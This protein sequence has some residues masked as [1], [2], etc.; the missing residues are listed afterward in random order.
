MSAASPDKNAIARLATDWALEIE[1]RVRTV[2]GDPNGNYLQQFTVRARDAVLIDELATLLYVVID[3]S[4]QKRVAGP[5]GQ[6]EL[7][8]GP[9]SDLGRCLKWLIHDLQVA[10]APY[11]AQ[12]EAIPERFVCLAD[13]VALDVGERVE[14]FQRDGFLNGVLM[15][16]QLH[17]INQLRDWFRSFSGQANAPL[18]TEH[19]MRAAPQWQR[20]RELARA[21][22]ATFGVESP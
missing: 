16:R 14:W 1:P 21:A 10:A 19:A 2:A 13:E 9:R 20:A 7:E 4:R 22:L 11:Q 18:W 17:A 12:R 5:W 8:D 15:E 6:T 3:E